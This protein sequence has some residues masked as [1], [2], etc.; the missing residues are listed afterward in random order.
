MVNDGIFRVQLFT[1]SY[2]VYFGVLVIMRKTATKLLLEQ[3]TTSSSM[4]CHGLYHEPQ[5]KKKSCTSL[6]NE[7]KNEEKKLNN[8]HHLLKCYTLIEMNEK[9]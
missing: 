3:I 7:A 9:F 6:V 2:S 5:I 8:K 4:L 1:G